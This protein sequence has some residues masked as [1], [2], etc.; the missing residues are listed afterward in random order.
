[1][2]GARVSVTWPAAFKPLR[3][4]CTATGGAVCPAAAG[5]GDIDATADLPAGGA[6][7]YTQVCTMPVGVATSFTAS[8]AVVAPGSV[9]TADKPC[10]AAETNKLPLY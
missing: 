9:C 1:M 3:W 6:L 4:K 8:I 7:T 10:V 5:T 2:N